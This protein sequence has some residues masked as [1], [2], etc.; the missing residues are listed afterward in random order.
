MDDTD[1]VIMFPRSHAKRLPPKTLEEVKTNLD[2]VKNTHI[3]ETIEMLVPLIFDQLAVAGFAFEGDS[4]DEMKRAALMVEA[5]RSM[6]CAHYEIKHPLQTVAKKVF[7][8][9]KDGSLSIQK[10]VELDLRDPK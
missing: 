1:N 9:E 7:K 10:V 8:F 6:L 3:Y 4:A 2:L 5:M